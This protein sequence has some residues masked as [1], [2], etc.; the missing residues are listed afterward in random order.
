MIPPEVAPAA[1]PTTGGAAQWIATGVPLP[2]EDL[3][4][5][6]V[7]GPCTPEPGRPDAVVAPLLAVAGDTTRPVGLVRVRA[8][9]VTVDTAP[10]AEWGARAALL[11]WIGGWLAWG[12]SRTRR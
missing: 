1:L 12:W 5:D 10:R 9:V 7:L 4:A 6:R 3:P 11:A 2:A 8:G